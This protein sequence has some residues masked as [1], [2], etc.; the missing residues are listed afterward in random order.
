MYFL[1]HSVL[2]LARYFFIWPRREPFIV[3]IMF[4]SSKSIRYNLGFDI[5]YAYALD[6]FRQCLSTI[7][8]LPRIER[9]NEPDRIRPG[10]VMPQFHI[11]NNFYTE[12]VIILFN[13][14]ISI[15]IYLLYIGRVGLCWQPVLPLSVLSGRS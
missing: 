2:L 6:R 1:S 14:L 5:G 8:L 4:R 13:T 3:I 11:I 7:S 10:P 12:W 9:V 15:Q